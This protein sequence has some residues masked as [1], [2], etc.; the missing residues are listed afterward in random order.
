MDDTVNG[1]TKCSYALNP[2]PAARMTCGALDMWQ[3]VRGPNDAIMTVSVILFVTFH[4]I[5]VSCVETDNIQA[6]FSLSLHYLHLK[7]IKIFQKVLHIMQYTNTTIFGY[8]TFYI[9]QKY[10]W[11]IYNNFSKRPFSKLLLMDLL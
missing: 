11:A 8:K 2:W 10:L 7:A 3:R 5:S 6:G 9:I 1:Q 4:C